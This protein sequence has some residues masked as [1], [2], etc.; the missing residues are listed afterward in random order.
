MNRYILPLYNRLDTAFIKG[1]KTLLF[2]ENKKDYIDFASG[3]GVNSLG[4]AN[5]KVVK[6]I[7]KQAKKVLHSSNIYLLITYN[8]KGRLIVLLQHLQ[9]LLC[10][11][12]FYTLPMSLNLTYQKIEFSLLPYRD[13]ETDRKSTRLNSSHRSLSRMPSSA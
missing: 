9:S 1:K 4:Y 8:L 12:T 10:Y 7:E 2:D 11:L 3:V 5:K 6:T 13:W